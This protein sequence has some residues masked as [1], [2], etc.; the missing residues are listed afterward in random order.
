MSLMVLFCLEVK[1]SSCDFLGEKLLTA[2]TLLLIAFDNLFFNIEGRFDFA[3]DSVEIDVVR[4][5]L[6]DTKLKKE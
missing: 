6:I 3:D 4:A 5:V 1:V 2:L